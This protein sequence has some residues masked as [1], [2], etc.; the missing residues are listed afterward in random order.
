MRTPSSILKLCFL[1]LASGLFYTSVQAQFSEK[2][3]VNQHLE[4]DP[5]QFFE[6]DLDGDGDLDMVG[7]T[8][9][10]IGW[11][12]NDGNGNF[13]EFHLIEDSLNTGGLGDALIVGLPAPP[14]ASRL[15]QE[16]KNAF[17]GCPSLLWILL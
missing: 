16:W 2:I 12:E 5:L 15:F 7:A 4:D 6:G 1:L 13:I 10:R 9:D 8:F 3:K 11:K 17:S 14:P